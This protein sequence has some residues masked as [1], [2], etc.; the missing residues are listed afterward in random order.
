MEKTFHFISG[1]P[2]SGSSLL[3]N[4]LAQNP[5]FCVSPTSGILDIMFMVRNG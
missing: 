4:V 5:R 3:A 1:L 2:R